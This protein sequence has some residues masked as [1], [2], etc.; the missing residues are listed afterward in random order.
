MKPVHGLSQMGFTPCLIQDNWA[1]WSSI[2]HN[3]LRTKDR[4]ITMFKE[5]TGGT[6]KVETSRVL[7]VVGTH[8][9]NVDVEKAQLTRGLYSWPFQGN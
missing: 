9:H 3:T 8:D 4:H 1:S 5:Q 6:P 7:E 2:S